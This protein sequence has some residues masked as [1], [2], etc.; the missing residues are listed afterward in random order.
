[1]AFAILRLSTAG[2]S[3]ASTPTGFITIHY[4]FLPHFAPP[5]RYDEI[6]TSPQNISAGVEIC[7]PV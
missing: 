7:F 3:A 5:L 1:M 2:E 4:Y 6:P